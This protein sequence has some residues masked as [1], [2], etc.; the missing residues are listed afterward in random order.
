MQ[1]R[2]AYNH[3]GYTQ[4]RNLTNSKPNPNLN[5]LTLTVTVV[6][7]LIRTNQTHHPLLGV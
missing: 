7:G 3:M 1:D 2:P 4:D 6:H 5:S